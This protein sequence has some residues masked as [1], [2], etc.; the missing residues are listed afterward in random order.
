MLLPISH[1][2]MTTRRLPVVTITLIALT[3]VLHGVASLLTSG[4]EHRAMEAVTKAHMVYLER[5]SQGVCAPLKPFLEGTEADGALAGMLQK[6]RGDGD[7]KDIAERYEAA[8]KE[9]SVATDALPNQRFGYVPARAN[10]LGLF[11]YVFMHADVWHVIGN[12]WFL[13]LCGLALEDRW[14]RLPFAVYYFVAGVVAAGVHHL[15]LPD[16]TAALIGASGAVAGAMGAFVVLFATTQIRFIGFLGFRV[17]SFKAPAYVMLPLWAI[18]EV[19]YGLVSHASGTAHWA[20]VGGFVF[21]LAAAGIFRLAGVDKRLDDAVERAAVLGD[22]PRLDTAR[23]MVAKGEAEQAVALL[24]GLL[25]EKP[26]STH[27]QEALREAR[28]SSPSVTPSGRMR[29]PSSRPSAAPPSAS[30][31]SVRPS[32]PSVRPSVPSVP[33]PAIPPMPAIPAMPAIMAEPEA[34]PFFPAPPPKAATT[35]R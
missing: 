31:P 25:Q 21:G 29:T 10:F 7:E 3:I 17:W 35:K 23:A 1:E 2:K 32:V 22:D 12:M 18:V 19:L 16:S 4:L 5:P 28:A 24:E 15:A 33:V 9:V 8:C 30:A 11:T 13:F 6:L 34:A 27:V 26:G 20:H 14:G